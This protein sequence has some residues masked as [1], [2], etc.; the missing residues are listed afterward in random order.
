ML[1][2]ATWT[3]TNKHVVGRLPGK[4]LNPT[5]KIKD[6]LAWCPAEKGFLG[7][8]PYKSIL[9]LAQR[10]NVGLGNLL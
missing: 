2:T 3:Q 7:G 5:S 9:A 8:P 1:A 10:F 4:R 6:A